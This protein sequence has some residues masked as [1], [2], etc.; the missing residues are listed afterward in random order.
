MLLA[1]CLGF[2]KRPGR[3]LTA[4]LKFFN[5]PTKYSGIF[6]KIFIDISYIEMLYFI[7]YM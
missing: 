2:G 5:K 1:F 4:K 3:F 7:Y 6:N